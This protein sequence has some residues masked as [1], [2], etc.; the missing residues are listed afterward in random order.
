MSSRFEL[1]IPKGQEEAFRVSLASS[2]PEARILFD[3]SQQQAKKEAYEKALR[4]HIDGF[5]IQK[6]PETETKIA[7][8]VR[9][10]LSKIFNNAATE[11]T[12]L[13]LD[14][15]EEITKV[16]TLIHEAFWKETFWKIDP[17]E[18][19]RREIILVEQNGLNDGTI[20]TKKQ[21]GSILGVSPSTVRRLEYP[22][23]CDVER[24]IDRGGQLTTDVLQIRRKTPVSTTHVQQKVEQPLSQRK[25]IKDLFAFLGKR[26]K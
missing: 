15:P 4:E 25:N 6:D 8:N 22:A 3:E 1:D 19:L 21:I 5:L 10:L 7:T 26:K 20:K 9:D 13:R 23:R 18:R 17:S 16:K 2:F 14:T 11:I 12:I 24:M